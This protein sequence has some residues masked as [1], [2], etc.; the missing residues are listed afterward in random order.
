[1]GD[2]SKLYPKVAGA[3]TRAEAAFPAALARDFARI[4]QRIELFWGSCEAVTYFNSLILGDGADGTGRPHRTGR[5][6]FPAEVLQDLVHLKQVH[7]FLFPALSACPYDPFSGLEGMVHERTSAGS[8]DTVGFE[9]AL[10]QQAGAAGQGSNGAASASTVP[11]PFGYL[12]SQNRTGAAEHAKERVEWPVI[13]TQRELVESSELWRSGANIYALQGKL[14][15]EILVH[16]GIVDE[17]TLRIVRRMQERS[18]RKGEAIG[19]I[20]VEIGII[21]QDDLIRALCIQSGVLMVDILAT[22]I[23]YETLKTVPTAKAREKQVVP[24]GIYYDTLFLAVADPFGFKDS[25]FFTILTGYKITPVFAPYHEIVNRLKLHGFGM[26]TG[27]AKEE[28]RNLAMQTAEFSPGMPVVEEPV[29]SDVSE[30]D[31]TIISL[32]NK[33]MLN[34]IEAGAS[35]IHIELFQGKTES[36]IRFRR[37]GYMENFSDF[38]SAYHNAVVSRIKI[39]SGLDISEKRRPQDGK[40]SFN[41]PDGRRI[42][43]RVA[44]IPTMRGAEFVTIRILSSGEP[45]PLFDLGMEERDMKMFRES[46]Q[47]PYGLILVCGPTGSGKTTTLHSVLKE[48]NTGDRKIWTVEDPVEI[49][50]ENLCQVQVNTKIGMTFAAVLRSFLRADPDIIMIGEMRDQETA[51]IALEA[52]MTGHLVLSTL[53]TNSAT[54]TV[55][56][57]LDLGIDP[58]NLSDALLAIVAQR[59]ARKL[60]P[61][62]ARREEASAADMENL[63]NEYWLSVH[64]NPP[65]AAERDAIIQRWRKAFGTDGKLYLAHAVGC[66]MCSGGYKGRI[67]LYE[68]LPAAPAMRRLIRQRSAATEYLAAGVAG[69][70]RTLKQDGIEKVIRGVTDIMQ[71]RSVCV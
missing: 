39:M 22:S 3:L 19:Q 55:A 1:M 43:L 32:V 49:V 11:H 28:F 67:G 24:V 48:L 10:G 2:E 54:E 15:G 27:E 14:V 6:G 31:S 33:M 45:L 7:E 9:S 56:R 68:L 60:C 23:P 51:K 62:C 52:S 25:P 64:A 37:D 20:L 42:D 69:G 57:L 59:L 29:Y 30:N 8:S 17:R 65:S 13:H 12:R 21:K 5:R 4:L 41:T 61:A 53:H 66:K 34:A 36:S 40:I 47:R 70:M 58:Y 63:A 46:F 44:T 71:V 18:E 38:P 16:Y 50:Q 35:D 26:S